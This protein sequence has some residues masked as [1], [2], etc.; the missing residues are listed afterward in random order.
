MY[1]CGSV[2][3]QLPGTCG[4]SSPLR[5]TMRRGAGA[6]GTG[7]LYLYA[8]AHIH[9]ILYVTLFTLYVLKLPHLLE[10]PCE[11]TY[12]NAH[13]CYAPRHRIRST[14]SY[15]QHVIHNS[16]TTRRSNTSTSW[17]YNHAVSRQRSKYILL[18][19]GSRRRSCTL[20]APLL[21]VRSPGG[22]HNN[23]TGVRCSISCC[24]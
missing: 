20:P 13:A 7:E 3:V 11:C 15:K 16:N 24:A 17:W 14:Y 9:R 4:T 18:R 8:S 2:K 23:T 12:R 22:V 21:S 19:R 6:A 5:G 1:V 10:H